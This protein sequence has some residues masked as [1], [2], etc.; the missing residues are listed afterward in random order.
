MECRRSATSPAG[1]KQMGLVE[2]DVLN[3]IG[4][5]PKFLV[6]CRLLLIQLPPPEGFSD[7]SAAGYL[8][9]DGYAAAYLSRCP[10]NQEGSSF[11]NFPSRLWNY[12]HTHNKI[13]ERF[14]SLTVS[15]S[16]ALSPPLNLP[17][18]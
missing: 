13:T 15:P 16:L 4:M 5:M 18:C 9:A 10:V 3:E 12:L 14:H 1:Q 6:E 8:P 7:S 2:M 11:F 17:I